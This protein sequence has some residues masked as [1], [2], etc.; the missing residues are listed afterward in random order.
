MSA[1]RISVEEMAYVEDQV[2]PG[3]QMLR[4]DRILHTKRSL[5]SANVA[6]REI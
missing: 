2:P 3:Y 5:V 4:R 1:G 6:V